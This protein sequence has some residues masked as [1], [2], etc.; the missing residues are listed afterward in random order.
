MHTSGNSE[1]A[2]L[3][4]P[5]DVPKQFDAPQQ[6]NAQGP[7]TLRHQQREQFRRGGGGCVGEVVERILT[8]AAA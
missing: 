5:G 4:P 3:N 6:C 1:A 8:P 2:S 7:D